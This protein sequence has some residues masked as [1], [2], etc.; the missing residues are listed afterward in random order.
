MSFR[1]WLFSFYIKARNFSVSSEKS[2]NLSCSDIFVLNLGIQNPFKMIV[3]IFESRGLW[4]YYVQNTVVVTCCRYVFEQPQFGEI[5]FNSDQ[6][7][8]F[9]VNSSWGCCHP[10][11]TQIS[12]N[13]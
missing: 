10:K 8:K 9:K 1:F 7:F 12:E 3:Q 5:L 11:M 6:I 4:K 13:S 2:S